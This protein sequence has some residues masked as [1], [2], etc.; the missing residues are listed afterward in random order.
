MKKQYK[1]YIQFNS[2]E[3]KYKIFNLSFRQLSLKIKY[4]N[5]KK[6]LVGEAPA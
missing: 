5:L 6:N 1:L 3:A 4:I 2:K